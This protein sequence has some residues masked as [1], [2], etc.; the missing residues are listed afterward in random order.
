MRDYFFTILVTSLIGGL[1]CSLSDTKFEKP[2]KYVVSLVCIVLILSPIYSV[3]SGETEL[4]VSLPEVSIDEGL[5]SDW[6]LT[7][8][9]NMLK[10]TISEAIF[11]KYGF[12]PEKIELEIATR[13]GVDGLVTIIENV[14]VFIKGEKMEL[15]DDIRQFLDALLFSKSE[16]LIHNE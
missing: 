13:D 16:V 11:S 5:A 6:I 15:I 12:F 8:T 3:F 14:K 10:K 1:V 7:E 4:E 9:E 2:I